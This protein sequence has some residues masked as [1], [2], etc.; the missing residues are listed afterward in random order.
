MI[1]DVYDCFMARRV[2]M[3]VIFENCDV[4]PFMPRCD[5]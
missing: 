4:I 2:D 5:L 3:K 1:F